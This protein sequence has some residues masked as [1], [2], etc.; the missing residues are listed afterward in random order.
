MMKY[1]KDHEWVRKDGDV[2][3]VGITQHAAD[4]LGDLVFI[5]LP[6]VGASF[7]AGAD[8]ATVESVKAASEIYAPLAGEIAEVNPA[9]AEDPTKVSADP[10]GEGWFFK[11]KAS[12]PSAYDA[13]MDEAAYQQ[14]LG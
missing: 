3:V 10:T 5:E 2:F 11:I 7:E 9:I 8:A 4:E 13:L 1:T 14:L 12:D 6:E